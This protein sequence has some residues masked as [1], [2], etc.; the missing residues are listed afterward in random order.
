MR[1][2]AIR[3]PWAPAPIYFKKRTASTMEDARR[4]FKSGCPDGTVV[5]ADFQTLGRGRVAERSW[6][7]ESGEN[8]LFTLVLRTESGSAGIGGVP[9]R[10]PLVAGLAL[11]LSV[12]RLYGL[13]VQLKW[14]NDL[15]VGERKLAGILCEALVEGNSLGLLVGIGLNCNQLTFPRELDSKATSLAR[16]LGSPVSLPNLL[17]EVLSQLKT[18]IEDEDWRAKVV[19]RLY[20]LRRANAA[21]QYGRPVNAARQAQS[22]GDGRPMMVLLSPANRGVASRQGSEQRGVILG[23]NPD[24]SLLVQPEEGPPVSVYGGEI[25]FVA[26]PE[27]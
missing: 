25:R 7:A 1:R 5:L 21:R 19:D 27:L 22:A 8:L 24:G 3:N 18:C 2:L 4:L 16:A 6:I 26:D 11:A 14:P 13:S 10:L 12:E 17:E 23:V 20:G 9:Q 15:L